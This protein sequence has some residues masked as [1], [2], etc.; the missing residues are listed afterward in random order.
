M[1]KMNTNILIDEILEA[2]NNYSTV[3]SECEYLE[4]GIRYTD[5]EL[6]NMYCHNFFRLKNIYINKVKNVE[7]DEIEFRKNNNQK[8]IQ[9]EVFNIRKEEVESYI[10]SKY[11]TEHEVMYVEIE[12]LKEKNIEKNATIKIALTDDDHEIGKEIDC[13]AF[14][15][16]MREFATA[17]YNRKI[18][19]YK[20]TE[21]QIY[22]FICHKGDELIGNCDFF[23]NNKYGKIEDFD[24]LDKYQR[25]GYG[26]AI[27][28]K[29]KDFG[30]ENG[31]KILFLQVEKDNSAVE[32]Y[33]KL[34]FKRLCNNMIYFKEIIGEENREYLKQ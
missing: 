7:I 21:V 13:L 34:G 5:D 15:E 31:V 10:N 27:I 23:I 8:V 14:G 11:L 32:M 12:E 33:N 29:I 4:Y 24:V 26:T 25:Q 2:E 30:K 1:K 22:N 20:D 16:K 17:R 9:I 19:N 18:R 28:E 3:F 6:L